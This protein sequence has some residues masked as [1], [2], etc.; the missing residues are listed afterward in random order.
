MTIH[1][2]DN[3]DPETLLRVMLDFIDACSALS[4]AL[5]A[6]P[7]RFAKFREVLGGPVRDKW[8]DCVVTAPPVPQTLAGFEAAL[9]L[10]T[11]RCF[12]QTEAA[13]DQARHF[14]RL[15]RSHFG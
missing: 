5:T 2:C 3:G 11:T 10:L 7:G 15:S 6:G 4:L 8:D 9:D 14:W 12:K 1:K 13:A